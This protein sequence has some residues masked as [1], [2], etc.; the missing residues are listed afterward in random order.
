MI[1]E[2]LVGQV[3]DYELVPPE[4]KTCTICFRMDR[5]V[6]I[7]ELAP[8]VGRRVKIMLEEVNEE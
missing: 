6:P 3:L 7:G 8:F 5:N 2:I 4:T 1:K